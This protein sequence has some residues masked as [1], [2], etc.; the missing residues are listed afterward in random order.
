MCVLTPI[1]HSELF[2][3]DNIKNFSTKDSKNVA[4][5]LYKYWNDIGGPQELANKLKSNLKV[6]HLIYYHRSHFRLESKETRMM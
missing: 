6:S 2:H 5:S 1:Y 4:V 3:P